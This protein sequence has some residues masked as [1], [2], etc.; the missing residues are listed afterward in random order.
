[1]PLRFALR[2]T[3]AFVTCAV[4]VALAADFE[5]VFG[6]PLGVDLSALCAAHGGW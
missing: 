5:R 3:A 4:V 2:A 1:M 6:T